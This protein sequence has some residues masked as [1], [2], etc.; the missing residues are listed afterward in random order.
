MAQHTPVSFVTVSIEG[1]FWRERLET[2]LTR[3]IPAQHAAMEKAGVFESVVMAEA[4]GE[5]RIPADDKGFTPQIFW[6]AEIG[7]WLEAASYGLAYRRQP[8]IEGQIETIGAALVKTQAEDGYLNTWFTSR[9]PKERW[10]NLRDGYELYS[11]GHLIEA[12]VAHFQATGERTLMDPL[13]RYVDHIAATFGPGEEQKHGYAGHEGIALALVRL[14]GVTREEKHLDLAQYFIDARGQAPNF[15]TIEALARGDDEPDPRGLAFTQSH[16][17]VR[18]E[19]AAVGHVVRAFALYA[20]MTCMASE[21]RDG[22]LKRAVEALWQDVTQNQMYVTGGVGQNADG[23][24]G[25]A[26]ELPNETAHAETAAAVGLVH[27]AKRI[28]ALDLDGKYA[29]VLE[30]ALYNAALAGL[31]QDGEHAFETNPLAD[32]GKHRRVAWSDDPRGALNIARLIASVGGLFYSVAEDG[33]AVHLYGGA[34]ATLSIGGRAVSIRE[35]SDYPWSG[36]IRLTIDPVEAGEFT[37]RLRIPAF[38]REAKARINGAGIDVSGNLVRGYLEIRRTWNPGDTVD[39]DL[40]MPAERIYANPDVVADRG[41]VA[42]KRGPLVYCFEAVD[43]PSLRQMRLPAT[44]PL[45]AAERDDLLGGITTITAAATVAD[46]ATPGGPL[47]GSERP[48]TKAVTW[49][50]VPYFAWANREAGAM[51]VWVNED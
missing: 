11:A 14:H 34:S 50:A 39:L 1:D 31:S 6:D 47:Y 40:P 7:L 26:R 30:L 38:A 15:F 48:P 23:T 44:A 41:R 32:D 43:N 16:R 37:L 46:Q 19:D 22:A 4:A 17:P 45:A 49:T 3:T 8:T 33:L 29:D 9:A 28:L 10:T 21:R 42:L 12:A 24:F 25:K 27:W 51:Q 5:L 13:L 20:G 36:K 18:N 35:V 2:V